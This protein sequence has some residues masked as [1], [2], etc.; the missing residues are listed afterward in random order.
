MRTAASERSST[1]V[2]SSKKR[3]HVKW[4]TEVEKARE[5]LT[6]LSRISPWLLR[7]AAPP[8]R[9][10]TVAVEGG[11]LATTP[12]EVGVAVPRDAF[13]EVAEVERQ[14]EAEVQ[15]EVAEEEL[16]VHP[17]CCDRF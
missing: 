11:L 4:G 8:A 14:W 13:P 3:E 6:A 5:S 17:T 15:L 12:M 2:A 7:G 1:K 10:R 9:H 16:P